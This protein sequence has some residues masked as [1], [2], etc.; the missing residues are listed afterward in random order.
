MPS[1]PS[2][3]EKPPTVADLDSTV[4]TRRQ[5]LN[6]VTQETRF[7]LIQNILSHPRQLPSLKELSYANLSKSQSTIHEHLEILIEDGIVEERVLSDD[8]RQRDLPWRFYGLTE[9]GRAL[10]LEAGLSSRSDVT[11][12]VYAVG[13]HGRDR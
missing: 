8:R 6:T 10:L 2:N 11:G 3:S 13:H 1:D 5:R 7:V 12:Y 4:E 9:E